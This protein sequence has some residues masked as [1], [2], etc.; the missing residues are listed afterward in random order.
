MVQ[1][2]NGILRFLACGSVDDGKS[3]LIGHLVHLTGNLPDDQLRLLE[4]ESA[5][6]GTAD[7]SLDYS[8]LMDGLMAEREQGITIDVAYRYFDTPDRKFIV[9]DTPGHEQYTRNMATGASRCSA[10]VILVDATLG[11]L[12]QT[13]RH[14][15]ICALMGVGNL[16]FAVNKMDRAGWAEAPFRQIEQECHCMAED[17]ALVAAVP[18]SFRALPVSALRGD[19]LSSPS[20]RMPW[21]DNS[22]VLGWLQGLPDER[23]SEE[24]PFRMPVQYVL[25]GKP[26]GEGWRDDA[27]ALTIPGGRTTWRSYAG[28]VSSGILRK[29]DRVVVLPSAVETRVEMLLR[30]DREAEEATEGMAVSVVLAGEQ[31]ISRGDCIAHPDDRPEQAA[32]FRARLVWMGTATLF[33]GRR[34]LFRSVFGTTEAEITRIRGRIGLETFQQLSADS[35]ALNDI[36]EV[37]ISLSRPLPFDPYHRNRDTGSFILIDRTENSTVAC[38]MIRYPM[39]RGSNIHRQREDVSREQRAA[40]KGQRPCVVWLTGLSGSGKSTVANALEARLNGMGHHTMLLDGDNVRHG[41]NH[42]LG[43]TEADRV[44]NI[45]RIGE[46]AKLMVDAGLIVITAFIS[47]FQADRDTVRALLLPG[48]FLEV[49]LSTPLEVCE[50]RDPKGLYAKARLGE[51]PNFTGINSPYEE[52]EAPELRLD[53]A[54]LSAEACAGAVLALLETGGLLRSPPNGRT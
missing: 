48:E 34:Y 11:V 25:K 46:V 28:T 33:A 40:L 18:L 16:L 36:G 50:Q 23:T 3:T 32:L 39:R 22:T 53:T 15:L 38:G 20:T 19:N 6:I 1:K 29:G 44:E 14:T 24:I 21:H 5:R 7:G 9:A 12:P 41:L 45:R 4:V 17:A 49:H 30:G 35:L 37:E 13:R 52:P 42:D 31:D 47:P 54:K 8:L 2:E 27:G 26:G 51:I 43:F 10:A